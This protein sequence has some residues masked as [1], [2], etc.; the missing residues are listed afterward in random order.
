MRNFNS[1]HPARL[2]SLAVFF[3]L[4]AVYDRSPVRTSADSR[5]SIA[6]AMSFIQGHDG[7]LS[8]YQKLL[9]AQD[10]Y[11]IDMENGKPYP[12]FPIGASLLAVPFVAIAAAVQP[13]FEERLK[14]RVPA[15]FEAL[16][17]SFY[18]ALAAV[19]FFRLVLDRWD[20]TGTALA[21][22]F[23]FALCTSMWSMATRA[24][25]QHGP[26]I[27]MLLLAML[28][29]QQASK[30]PALIQYVGL[31]LAAGFIIRPTALIPIAAITIYILVFYRPW[32]LRYAAGAVLVMVPW[33]IHN[34]AIY[35]SILPPY[36]QP[37]R[38][39]AASDMSEGMLGT[40]ISPARGLFVYSP[41]LVLAF[42]GFAF[43]L[44][45][46]RER[47][48]GGHTYGPRLMADALPFL[49]Y[50]VS[51]NFPRVWSLAPWPRRAAILGV[52][53]LTTPSLIL[54]AEGALLYGSYLWNVR[55]QNV[56]QARY[57][58]WDWKDPP[59]LR[60]SQR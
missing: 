26:L 36:Y 50:F 15:N 5:W 32:S 53:V 6:E 31:P 25:W 39:S 11:A 30:R 17:A 27:L 20:S 16:V 35:H 48:W 55:P 57:R 19:V 21:S 13:S 28:L 4:I 40:L 41:V 29:L 3:I 12:F 18:G 37:G 58:L 45:E 22:T 43:A 54:H 14:E 51:F 24:L 38:I 42:S 23:I 9:D 46:S 44:Q 60:I 34:L 52:V 8:E 10:Y 59:F 7:N 2:L 47:W 49:A 33:A 56:D 1:A